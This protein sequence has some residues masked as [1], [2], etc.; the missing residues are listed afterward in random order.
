MSL[1]I[2][3]LQ[4]LYD[5]GKFTEILNKIREDYPQLSSLVN[6]PLEIMEVSA[7]TLYHLKSYVLAEEIATEAAKKNSESALEMLAQYHAYQTKNDAELN[8]IHEQLPNNLGVCNAFAI[9]ARDPDS[10]IDLWIVVKAA[11]DFRYVSKIAAIHLMHN[12]ARA[13]FKKGNKKEDTVL[14]ALFLEECLLR[15]QRDGNENLH[16]RATAAFWLSKAYN[17]VNL[18]AAALDAGE[19]ACI[20]WDELMEIDPQN[21]Q[22]QEKKQGS[23]RM[24]QP[25]L[26]QVSLNISSK[27]ACFDDFFIK[28]QNKNRK[29]KIFR[30]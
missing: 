28:F 25:A 30:N 17:S 15:Y 29:D 1:N 6:A 7:W 24:V 3:E 8:R 4:E 10:T 19:I 11:M 5:R 18:K 27:P 13:L 9:R 12:A 22:Y 21:K 23:Q 20:Y 2:K 14:A 26:R 16:H